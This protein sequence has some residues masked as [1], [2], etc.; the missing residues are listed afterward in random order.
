MD[1]AERDQALIA[2]PDHPN[3][4]SVSRTPIET[5]LRPIEA[6]RRAQAS[7]GL[8]LIG[9]TVLALIWANSP[10]SAS[11]F[12]VWE[13]DLTIGVGPLALSKTLHHWIN[14]GLMAV[15]FF[16]I[17][18]EI[19]REFL[20][21]ELA[22]GRKAAL[23]IAGAVGG[24]VVPAALFLAATW[25]GP[26]MRGWGIA[27]ATDIAFAVGI[28][29]LLGPRVPAGVKVFLAALAIVDDIGA[30]LVIAVFYTASISL[31]A[32]GIGAIFFL[33]LLG[34]NRLGIRH[35]MP[36]AVLSLGLWA[37]LL[38]SGV[39]ATI[40]GVLAAMTVPA[41]T[42]LNPR[43]FLSDARKILQVFESE[44]DTEILRSHKR[45]AAVATLVVA[46]E[47][48]ESPMQRLEH[49]LEPWVGLLIMP[50]F[51]LAN[52]GVVFGT[53]FTSSFSEP[54]T[55]GIMAGLA[56]GKPIG[57]VGLC[58]IG[59]KAKLMDLPARVTWGHIVGAGLL[60]GIGFTMSLFVSTLAFQGTPLLD[61]AKAGILTGSFAAGLAG[62]ALLRSFS[63][64]H[65]P[66]L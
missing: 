14:D 11:Y 32:L 1:S 50:I 31:S 39:H 3:P 33:L 62:Y 60:G 43:E 48:V 42:R 23:P 58:W 2:D 61:V 56:L 25:G 12:H 20:V 51:A 64:F 19:K 4:P 34:T 26:G 57:I 49:A 38:A 45:Q 44:G 66:P 41:R 18:L 53:G 35:P 24:M 52:T 59:V 27:M 47:Q 30:V 13:T 28:L 16:V 8:L 10:W 7:R 40:A 54:L 37:S 55:L 15:F 5:L 22:T 21:G 17:G 65:R 29:A 46:C 63:H 9:S 36:Y 6:I